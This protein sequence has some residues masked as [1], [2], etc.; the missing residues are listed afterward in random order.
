MLSIPHSPTL[1]QW[2]GNTEDTFKPVRITAST[3]KLLF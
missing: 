1:Y 3:G 2:P